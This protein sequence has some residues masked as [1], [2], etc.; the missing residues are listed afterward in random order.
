MI[1]MA[2]VSLLHSTTPLKLEIIVRKF[3]EDKREIGGF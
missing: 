1:P 2:L 3:H